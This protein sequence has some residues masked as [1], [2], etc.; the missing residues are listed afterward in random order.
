MPWCLSPAV[1]P[2][3]ISDPQGETAELL[4]SVLPLHEER[5]LY[6]DFEVKMRDPGSSKEK[7][8]PL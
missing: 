5:A 3:L 1:L 2:L 8:Y 4:V 6:S 7:K